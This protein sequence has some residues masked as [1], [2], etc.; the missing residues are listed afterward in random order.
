MSSIY[1]TASQTLSTLT[2]LIMP[3][4]IIIITIKYFMT[5]ILA[6]AKN[7]KSSFLLHP[8]NLSPAAI[9]LLKENKIYK[10]PKLNQTQSKKLHLTLWYQR[11]GHPKF[12]IL[13]KYLAYHNIKFINDVER[14][15]CNS[16][17]R[18]KT[19]K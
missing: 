19:K 12:T 15:I 9:T 18:A 17:K 4:S 1:Q 6:F 5:K 10:G 14:F 8:L 13:K 11:L 2:S 7:Y 3:E 16:Y